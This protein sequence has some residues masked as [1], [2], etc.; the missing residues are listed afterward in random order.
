LLFYFNRKS[1]NQYN[2]EWN[3]WSKITWISN[4]IFK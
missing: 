4:S 2:L 3:E 1:M